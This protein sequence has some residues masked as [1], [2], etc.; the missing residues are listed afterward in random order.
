MISIWHGALY[1]Y[2]YGSRRITWMLSAL[3]PL[4]L[5]TCRRTTSEREIST[6]SDVASGSNSPMTASCPSRASLN[7]S[8]ALGLNVGRALF[9]QAAGLLTFLQKAVT[10]SPVRDAPPRDCEQTT[11]VGDFLE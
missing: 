10:R 5:A 11:G 4:Q 1:R 7:G 9:S 3:M 2:S 6:R 8:V